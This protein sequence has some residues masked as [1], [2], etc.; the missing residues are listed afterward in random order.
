MDIKK[1]LAYILLVLVLY[2]SPA[3]AQQFVFNRVPLFEENV[4]G[5]I[6]SMAQDAN[7][8]MWFTGTSLYRYDG[9]RVVTFKHDPKNPK[10]IAPSRLETIYIDQNNIM[11]IGTFGSGL[12]SFD[13]A[14]GIFTH[15]PNNPNDH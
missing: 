11:W 9:Y 3:A 8:Y 10:S 4:R 12:D 5:F 13:P 6:T 1:C 2:T 14:T 15:Y 7:G